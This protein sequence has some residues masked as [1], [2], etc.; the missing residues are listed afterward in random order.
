MVT[1]ETIKDFR[2]NVNKVSDPEK[3]SKTV[4]FNAAFLFMI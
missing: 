4:L 3:V 1:A 2:T